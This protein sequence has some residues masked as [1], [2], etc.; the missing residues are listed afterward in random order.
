MPGSAGT[1][2]IPVKPRSPTAM[3]AGRADDSLVLPHSEER[4]VKPAER[5]R[6]LEF[7]R[8]ERSTAV[9]NA[10]QCQLMTWLSEM[11][12]IPRALT[13]SS[14]RRALAA[15]RRTA[16]CCIS[17]SGSPR[18]STSARKS[19][20]EPTRA[21][22]PTRQTRSVGVGK[23]TSRA[24]AERGSVANPAYNGLAGKKI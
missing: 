2:G 19:C 15:T 5:I 9:S 20:A 4:R 24:L 1:C 3:T 11:P 13:R 6:S 8:P 17:E 18:R 10:W 23:G 21:R 7:A 16:R 12:L 14:T 22:L